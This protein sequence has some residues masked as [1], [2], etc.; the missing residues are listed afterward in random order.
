MTGYRVG[1]IIAGP[2]LPG[3]NR[4]NSRLHGDLRAAYF[5]GAPRCSASHLDEWKAEKK[6]GMMLDALAALRKAFAQPGLRLSPGQGGAFFAYVEHPFARQTAK[7]VAMRLAG[8][9]TCCAF[10]ARCSGR[11]RTTICGIAFA[12]VE[13]ALMAKWLNRLIESQQD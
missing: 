3:R 13:A 5:A 2:A 10:R 7:E 4:K 12:N 8:D 6:T 11:A 1:S 9:M